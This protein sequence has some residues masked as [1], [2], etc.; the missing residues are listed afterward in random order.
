MPIYRG[1]SR[2][3]F[4]PARTANKIKS[5]LFVASAR[6]ACLIPSLLSA[7]VNPIDH[8]FG[9]S[10]LLAEKRLSK[11]SVVSSAGKGPLS[12]SA[13]TEIWTLPGNCIIAGGDA[14][15]AA[16]IRGCG[17]VIAGPGADVSA[18]VATAG[19]ADFALI[20]ASVLKASAYQQRF[21]FLARNE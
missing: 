17:G 14:G 10:C 6:V 20:F 16:V 1:F 13:L 21:A 15:V 5:C 12:S 19:G 4:R 11:S 9:A 8:H 3:T 7:I 2:R 18:T